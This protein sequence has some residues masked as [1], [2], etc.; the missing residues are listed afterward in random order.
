MVNSSSGKNIPTYPGTG[1]PAPTPHAALALTTGTFRTGCGRRRLGKGLQSAWS[2]LHS[3]GWLCGFPDS[4]FTGNPGLLTG[5]GDGRWGLPSQEALGKLPGRHSLGKPACSAGPRWL[6]TSSSGLHVYP[7]VQRDLR[8]PC[9]CELQPKS[10]ENRTGGSTGCGLSD[11]SESGLCTQRRADRS[12]QKHVPCGQ[13]QTRSAEE[14]KGRL[15]RAAPPQLTRKQTPLAVC[16]CQS[17]L[18]SSHG[19]VDS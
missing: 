7:D 13:T 18:R 2:S 16:M 10:T 17:G 12:R 11:L 4:S 8:W 15:L 19:R 5:M 14:K 3:P 9:A 6:S 1:C